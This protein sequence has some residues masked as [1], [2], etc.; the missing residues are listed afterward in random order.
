MA[1]LNNEEEEEVP[2]LPQPIIP[3]PFSYISTSYPPI[4]ITIHHSP[5][6]TPYLQ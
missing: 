3:V 5:F 2:P 4:S 6:T 1:D